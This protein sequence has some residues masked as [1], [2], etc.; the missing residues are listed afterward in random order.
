MKAGKHEDAPIP[1]HLSVRFS[2]NS[3]VRNTYRG[4]NEWFH[5]EREENLDEKATSNPMVAGE[6]TK[7]YGL[8][9]NLILILRQAND[10]KYIFLWVRKTFS[11]QSTRNHFANMRLR[12]PSKIFEQYR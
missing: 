6:T 3:I 4:S 10:F 1:L 5:E 7:W 11:F 12:H 8:V 2:E 9:V